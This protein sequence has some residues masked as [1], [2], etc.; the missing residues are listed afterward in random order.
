[1]YRS[2]R[3]SY[4]RDLP[5]I[6]N[7]MSIA[8]GNLCYIAA[9]SI[10]T[11]LYVFISASILV[12]QE[13]RKRMNEICCKI[14]VDE[15]AFLSTVLD[16]WRHHHDLACS[17]VEKINRCFGCCLLF[18]IISS[19][20]TFVKYTCQAINGYQSPDVKPDSIRSYILQVVVVFFRLIVIL[21]VS[22]KLKFEVCIIQNYI[23]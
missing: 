20:M 2:T 15:T 13:L 17:L 19:N 10:Q 18:T 9:S 8:L 14:P 5:N 6:P 4:W 21:W 12:F 11:T 3:S 23:I 16:R 7:P 22:Q 1:M